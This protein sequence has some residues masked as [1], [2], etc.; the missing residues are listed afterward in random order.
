MLLTYITEI[1]LIIIQL[2]FT[3][4]EPYY[5]IFLFFKS[6]C[7]LVSKNTTKVYDPRSE[8][9]TNEATDQSTKRVNSRSLT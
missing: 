4:A 9:S 3:F 1:Y 6:S 2:C 7:A 5:N 8:G